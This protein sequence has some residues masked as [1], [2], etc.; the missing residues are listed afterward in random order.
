M[1]ENHKKTF[2]H[3]QETVVAT[4]I[5]LSNQARLDSF[6]ASVI[7]EKRYLSDALSSIRESKGEA[8]KLIVRNRGGAKGLHGFLAEVA[9]VGIGNARSIVQGNGLT[10][11]WVNNNGPEDLIRNGV[12]IQQKFVLSGGSF[13][14]NA[15]MEHLEKYPTF[16]K[17]G[18]KY[19][20]PSDFY[21]AIKVL[22]E[23]SG[24]EVKQLSDSPDAPFSYRQ[25]ARVNDFLTGRGLTLENIEP[26]VIAYDDAQAGNI[27]KTFEHEESALRGVTKKRIR[28]SGEGAVPT[29]ADGVKATAGAAAFESFT[30]ITAS[31]RQH[32]ADGKKLK[33]ITASEWE[34]ILQKAGKAGGRGGLRGASIHTLNKIV[35][36]LTVKFVSSAPNLV[37]SVSFKNIMT[38]SA[39]TASAVAS[40][41]LVVADLAS[42]KRKGEIREIEFLEGI[43]NACLETSLNVFFTVVGQSIIPIPVLGALIGATAG[44]LISSVAKNCLNSTEQV[45]IEKCI[46][47]QVNLERELAEDY[48]QLLDD[49]RQVLVDY[50][51]ILDTAFAP[52]IRNAFQGAV[53]LAQ[54]VG[55]EDAAILKNIEDVDQYFLI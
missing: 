4:L 52:D 55:V 45:L 11:E 3:A 17:E 54:L 10:Y 16:I 1:D 5:G 31:I 13:S 14:L 29:I 34:E 50:F 36:S 46:A 23:I 7:T 51:E 24:E 49:M 47:E 30:S 27:F 32:L 39:M 20:V 22:F 26:S 2:H 35:S 15:I 19:Q 42:K 25:W 8:Y 44:T 6:L 38:N 28:Q 41:S 9:E 48:Q 33:D 37:E 53:V 40:T 43:Q 21:D 12:K 18:G